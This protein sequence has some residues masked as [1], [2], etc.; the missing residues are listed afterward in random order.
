MKQWD[1]YLYPFEVE[2]PHPVVII[3]NDERCQNPGLNE[4]NALICTSF[5]LNRPPRDREI[6]LDDADGLDWRTAVRCDVIHLLSKSLLREPR[7]RVSEF[8]RKPIAQKIALW[9]RLPLS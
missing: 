5:R 4:V 7:G 3:S 1:I 8:R 9:L 2:Q 6:V